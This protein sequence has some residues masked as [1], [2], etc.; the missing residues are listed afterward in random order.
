VRRRAEEPARGLPAV[1]RA[2]PLPARLDG[3]GIGAT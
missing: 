2:V 3:A 1:N